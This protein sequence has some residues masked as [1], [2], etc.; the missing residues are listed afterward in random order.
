MRQPFR[1]DHGIDLPPEEVSRAHE[2][3]RCLLRPRP[4]RA[5]LLD[6]VEDGAALHEPNVGSIVLHVKYS[7]V[8]FFRL[9]RPTD[10]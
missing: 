8:T 3:D 5:G 9:A 7:S 10:G 4:E 2:R 6:L 1:T